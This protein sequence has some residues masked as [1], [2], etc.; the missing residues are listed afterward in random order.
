[1]VKAVFLLVSFLL[2][3][4]ASVAVL[5]AQDQEMG[6]A[7]MVLSGGKR[8]EVPFPHM[9]H[10]DALKDCMICHK[11]FP[12]EKGSIEGLKEKGELKKKKVMNNCQ[13]CHKKMAKAGEKSGPKSCKD[14]HIKKKK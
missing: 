11:L 12:Q 6:A 13:S 5:S 2:I 10:Q 8:G 1:M 14:C 7:D 3:S 9:R 4:F